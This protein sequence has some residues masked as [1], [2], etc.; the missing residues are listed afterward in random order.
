VDVGSLP[1]ILRSYVERV[2]PNSPKPARLVRV[3]QT[4]EMMLK[5]GASPRPFIAT[6]DFALDRVAFAWRARFPMLWPF[7]I[8]VT[9]SYDGHDGLLE[10]RLAGLPLQRKRGPALAKGEAFRY[11]AEIGWAPQAILW[12][13]T[14]EWR[15]R[16]ERTVELATS[17]G[18]ERIAVELLFNDAGEIAQTIARRPRLEAG[19]V[20][21]PWIGTYHDYRELGGVRVPISGEVRWELPEGSFT[22]WRGTVRSLQLLK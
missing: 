8:K 21:T 10:I 11:L 16:E 12:N 9:D 20:A 17:A 7:S 4:G 6:E 1:V 15:Q 14:L 13:P 5:R 19:N 3:E 2:L 22:Y 18:G